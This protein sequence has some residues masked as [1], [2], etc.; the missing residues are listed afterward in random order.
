MQQITYLPRTGKTNSKMRRYIARGELMA[1]KAAE[2]ANRGRTT[3]EIWDSIIKPVDEADVL[4]SLV[5]SL[6]SA[7]D[8]RKTLK[9]KKQPSSEFGVTAR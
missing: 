6:K 5:L 8:K 7:P 1:R 4:A 2:S 9:L 3:E